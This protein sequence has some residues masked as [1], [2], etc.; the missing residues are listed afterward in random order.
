MG[1]ATTPS[2]WLSMDHHRRRLDDRRRAHPRPEPEFLGGLAGEQGDNPRRLHNVDLD[3]GEKPVQGHRA[4]DAGEPVARTDAV[5]ARLAAQAL[6]L[7]GR[8]YPVIR[9]VALDPDLAGSIPPAQRVEADASA[10][11]ASLAVYVC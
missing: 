10:R 5:E 6:D 9:S 8:D 4:H 1:V 2:L 11:A 7:G 3:L